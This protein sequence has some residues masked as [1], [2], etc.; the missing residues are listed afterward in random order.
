[1]FRSGSLVLPFCVPEK[2]PFTKED[3][4]VKGDK[5][6]VLKSR[7]EVGGKITKDELASFRRGFSR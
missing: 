5:K 2:E 6:L 7:A 4:G 1:M 3:T